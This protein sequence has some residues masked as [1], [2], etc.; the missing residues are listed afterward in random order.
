MKL[1]I[2]II[3]IFFVAGIAFAQQEK[4]L[5]TVTFNKVGQRETFKKTDR[6]SLSR[7][8]GIQKEYTYFEY[9]P[10][11]GDEITIILRSN[12]ELFRKVGKLTDKSDSLIEVINQIQNK[13]KPAQIIE[14]EQN[15]AQSDKALSNKNDADN[16]NPSQNIETMSND[17]LVNKIESSEKQLIENDA[18]IEKN[19]NEISKNEDRIKFLLDEIDKHPEFTEK[20]KSELEN[21]KNKNYQLINNNENLLADKKKILSEKRIAELQFETI[22]QYNI[23]LA[24]SVALLL[25]V[26]LTIFI[27]FRNKK[28]LNKLLTATNKNLEAANLKLEEFNSQIL[29]QKEKLSEQNRSMR[30]SINYANRIQRAILPKTEIIKNAFNDFF[31]CYIPRD[32]VSGDFYWF[33][34]VNDSIFFAVADCTGHGVP[35]ALMS[36]I[37]NVIFNHLIKSEQ[38]FDTGAIL[39]ELHKEVRITLSQDQSAGQQ[40]DGMEASI[41]RLDGYNP[42][43]KNSKVKLHFSGAG[44]SIF[45]TK[46]GDVVELKGG[47]KSIGGRQ[48]E[49]KRTFESHVIELNSGDCFYLATDGLQDLHNPAGEKYGGRRLIQFLSSIKHLDMI[50]QQQS[51]KN[52]IKRFADNEKFVDDMT[53]A[54]IRV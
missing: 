35:G 41:V 27:G 29:L 46:N 20:Y 10:G 7:G 33:A 49:D 6:I 8:P 5:I 3:M 40:Q 50:Q 9:L 45:Y 36:M 38:I 19:R 44:R 39:E 48:K 1:S 11:I 14:T 16:A 22:K 26:A 2:Y 25:L 4:P 24:V 43:N 15:D 52:E 37:G 54:G 30:D 47:R 42:N 18:Q 23:F 51:I 17:E 13:N 28:K 21:L 31:I 12:E 53:I 32:V 34:R